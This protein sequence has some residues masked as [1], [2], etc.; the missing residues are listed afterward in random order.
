M[1]VG[2]GPVRGMA[3]REGRGVFVAFDIATGA[4]VAGGGVA[5]G[6]V[7]KGVMVIVTDG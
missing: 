6:I 3:E 7:A 2:V 5:V 1:L 4:A